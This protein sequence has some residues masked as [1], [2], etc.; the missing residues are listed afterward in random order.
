MVSI[1]VSSAQ[2]SILSYIDAEKKLIYGLMS[3]EVRARKTD[4]FLGEGSDRRGFMFSQYMYSTVREYGWSLAMVVGVLGA[5]KSYYSIKSAAKFM[6]MIDSEYGLMDP[7]EKYSYIMDNYMVFTTEELEEKIR[8]VSW[9]NRLP[10]LIW[11]DA[12][13]F[14]FSYLFYISKKLC[15][16]L[17]ALFQISRSRIANI[18][19]TTPNPEFILKAI[20]KI[21]ERIVIVI[22]KA[23][24]WT[25]LAKAYRYKISPKMMDYVELVFIDKFNK[26]MPDEFHQRYMYIRDKYVDIVLN[27]FEEEN[28]NV[29]GKVSREKPFQPIKR[30]LERYSPP[31]FSRKIVKWIN[32]FLIV[33]YENNKE[34]M[35]VKEIARSLGCSIQYLYNSIIPVLKDRGLIYCVKK[36]GC[37]LTEEGIDYARKLTAE[38]DVGAGYA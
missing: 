8:S 38:N 36:V 7:V 1:L 19:I 34:Y 28:V 11:D 3:G 22:E 2:K 6:E 15:M 9:E 10:L 33:L 4:S 17:A 25:S 13:V 37:S 27:L 24:K 21:P 30:S 26:R 12:G 14:G 23:G 35:T 32:K 18:V 16:K 29:F 31:S 5:G 20:R